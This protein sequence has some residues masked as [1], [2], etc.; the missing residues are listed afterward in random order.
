MSMPR[1]LFTFVGSCLGRAGSVPVPFAPSPPVPGPGP[2]TAAPPPAAPPAAPPGPSPT[3]YPA[4][5]KGPP[6]IA[7]PDGQGLSVKLQKYIVVDQFGYRTEQAKVAVLVDPVAGW[8]ANDAYEPGS[9]LEVRRW[10]DGTGVVKGASVEIGRAS[11]RER[12]RVSV[13]K[14]RV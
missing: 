10:S 5:P 9:E 11:W 6:P 12:E 1:R 14:D 2:T 7:P 4:E 13:G 8:N 3:A